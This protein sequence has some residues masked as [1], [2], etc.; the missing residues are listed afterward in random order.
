MPSKPQDQSDSS[1]GPL[2]RQVIEFVWGHPNCTVRECVDWLNASSEKQ[3]A[4]TTIQT[5][6]DALHRKKLV[7]R[8]RKKNAYYYAA[9]KSK[10]GLLGE[11]LQELF[12]K[13]GGEPGPVASS[14]VDSLQDSDP[15][16]LAA[17]IDE[18]KKRGHIKS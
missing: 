2:Q 16:Q 12:S 6:F 14:L 15:A 13:F 9:R 10:T 3:H 4:Y 8:R 17:L 5:V 1:L 7:A 18:L 11:L